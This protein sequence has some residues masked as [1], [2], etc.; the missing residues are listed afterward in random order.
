MKPIGYIAMAAPKKRKGLVNYYTPLSYGVIRETVLGSDSM[1]LM[2]RG[3]T[4]F[5]TEG[6]ATNALKDS[7]TRASTAGHLWPK[8]HVFVIWPV[9]AA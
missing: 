3:A 6:K 4:M 2:E 7:L 5:K 9:Y 1:L 8:S